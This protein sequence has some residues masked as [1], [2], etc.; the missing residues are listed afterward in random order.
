MTHFERVLADKERWLQQLDV[1]RDDTA[2]RMTRYP[3]A[4]WLKAHLDQ[5]ERERTEVQALLAT[6]RT[7]QQ[8]RA[9]LFDARPRWR[10]LKITIPK[11]VSVKG[12]S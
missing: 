2:R 3:K 6:L 9:L 7:L 12:A 5:L 10:M 1:A 8:H 11:P 4:T